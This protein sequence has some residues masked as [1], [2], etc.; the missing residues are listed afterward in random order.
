MAPKVPKAAPIARPSRDYQ[1]KIDNRDYGE[2]NTQQR[3]EE[4]TREMEARKLAREV[5]K[6]VDL[7]SG[8]VQWARTAEGKGDSNGKN[9]KGAG[10]GI[11]SGSAASRAKS[12]DPRGSVDLWGTFDPWS[13]YTT[14]KAG[15]SEVGGKGEGRSQAV[16]V[17]PRP[18]RV[19]SSAHRAQSTDP[20]YSMDPGS[21]SPAMPPARVVFTR[22]NGPV[23]D[24]A[25]SS[26]P[27][28]Q[29]SSFTFSQNV[30]KYKT[31][32]LSMVAAG[33]VETAKAVLREEAR[34]GRTDAAEVEAAISDFENTEESS[35]HAAEATSSVASSIGARAGEGDRAQQIQAAAETPGNPPKTVLLEKLALY[36]RMKAE[37]GEETKAKAVLRAQPRQPAPGV[38]AVEPRDMENII[39]EFERERQAAAQ[40]EDDISDEEFAEAAKPGRWQ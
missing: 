6:A 34:H 12:M 31:Y 11:S 8:A 19:V 33:K 23:A 17:N 16:P 29:A 21:S 27:P 2:D 7:G 26:G 4:R 20:L 9:S 28:S 30:R 22:S 18:P 15:R 14:P 35:Q 38:E 10:K 3:E 39:L 36:L 24:Q 5:G 32:L 37:K 13:Q 40:G 1:W 25:V